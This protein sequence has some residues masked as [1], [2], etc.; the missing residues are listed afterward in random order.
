MIPR[1]PPI[2][3]DEEAEQLILNLLRT[4]GDRGMTDEDALHVVEWA[5]QARVDISLLNLTLADTISVD[6]TEDGGVVFGKMQ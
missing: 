4:R 6:V 1:Q 2:I 5:T 3:S